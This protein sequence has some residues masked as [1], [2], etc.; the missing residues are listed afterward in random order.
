[1]SRRE[2]L[3]ELLR[4]HAPRDPEEQQH[5]ER[6]LALL[7]SAGD[8]FTRQHF[9]P[10]HFTA[11]GF[12]LSADGTALLLIHHAK[13]ARWLQPGGHIE[14]TDA[15]ALLAA[16]REV[17][18]EV[19][20]VELPLGVQGLFDLDVHAIPLLGD[21]P[22]HE[23]FD[24]RFLFRAREPAPRLGGEAQ[25]ARWFAFDELERAESDRSVLRAVRK[26]RG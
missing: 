23:H 10:G 6:M 1:M 15:D 7:D 13:L 17:Q 12:V 21:E 3:R 25:L 11:S 24:L 8:P 20:L 18:E 4:A 26:L 19:G 16:R 9:T 14:P 5:R 2:P 22:A